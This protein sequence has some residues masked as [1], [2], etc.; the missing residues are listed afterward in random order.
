MVLPPTAFRPARLRHVLPVDPEKQ[1]IRLS[2]TLSHGTPF[3]LDLE[4]ESARILSG[5]LVE[6][7]K[8]AQ[9]SPAQF[10]PSKTARIE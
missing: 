10:I 7:L 1:S 4:L 3:G 2:F 8:R 9:P 5:L 6:Q